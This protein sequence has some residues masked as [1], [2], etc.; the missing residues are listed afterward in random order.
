[1]THVSSSYRIK[2]V[3]FAILLVSAWPATA[4]RIFL[5]PDTLYVTSGTG[6]EYDFQLR[7]DAATS[8]LKLYQYDFAFH[9]L[10]FDTVSF[11]EGD[12]WDTTGASTVFNHLVNQAGT[13]IRLQGVVLGGGEA[14]DGPGWLSTVRLKIIDTGRIDLSVLSDTLKD[15]SGQFISHTAGGAVI[16]VDYPPN[17]FGLV[18]PLS[19]SSVVAT[20]CPGDSVTIRWHKS[21]SVYP[22]ESVV[23]KLEYGTSATFAV[24]FTTVINGLTDT[25]RRLPTTSFN[26][27]K[28]YWRVTASGTLYNFTRLSTPEI[29][30]FSV[31]VQDSDGDGVGNTCDNCPSVANA[32]QQDSDLDGKGDVCDNCPI[33]SN[34]GQGDGDG[35]GRGDACDN[36]PT[37]ANANQLDT[38]GDG[39]GDLCDNCVTTPNPTQTDTD[40]DGKGNACDNCATVANP[41]QTDTDGDGKGDAC[42]NCVTVANSNQLDADGDGVGSAC[43]NCPA[44]PNP[45]QEDVNHDGVGDA[46]CCIGFVAN[47]D[48]DPD[49]GV[50][51]ADLSALI[52]NLFIS[53]SPLCCPAEANVDGDGGVDISDLSELIDHL[54]IRFGLLRLC[55]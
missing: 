7:V 53:F 37:I 5:Q 9:T 55:P 12:F 54:F 35:D 6:G 26:Q 23:Y 28:Y 33:I 41:S 44:T 43:D 39:K 3:L 51:I 32:S 40:G 34:P 27:T 13:T 17:P 52:D 16:F 2:L 50:D 20:R 24:P 4:A 14:A 8:A 38:D 18:N 36:C 10:K 15:V 25:L 49:Q 19:N 48:C 31:S 42:D 21:T 47:V 30:S 1:M 29:D 45:L 46:C 22:G 11:T